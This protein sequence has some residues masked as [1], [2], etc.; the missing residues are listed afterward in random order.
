MPGRITERQVNLYMKS[1]NEGQTQAIASAKAGFSER[2]GRRIE[3]GKL[4]PSK[5]KER[6]WR[7]RADPFAEVWNSRLVPMLEAEP[8]LS[9]TTLLEMLQEEADPPGAGEAQIEYNDSMKRTLQRRVQ[10]WKAAHGKEKEVMFRQE[11]PP[12]RQGLSDFTT[13]KRVQ[14]LIEGPQ[15]CHLG[16]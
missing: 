11:H 16:L 7:T 6:H 4:N 9:A 10:V 8:K 2:S 13:L 14:V 3:G 5:R 1:K 15:V 12:G